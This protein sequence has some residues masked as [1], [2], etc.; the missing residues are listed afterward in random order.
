[1]LPK[2][3]IV[4]KETMKPVY[5]SNFS[6]DSVRLA[7]PH[8]STKKL[9]ASVR[10]M[11]ENYGENLRRE[12]DVS[13]RDVHECEFFEIRGPSVRFK[14][15]QNGAKMH[16]FG[17]KDVRCTGLVVPPCHTGVQSVINWIRSTAHMKAM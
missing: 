13:P 9:N 5:H 15:F 8:E 7:C 16:R 14:D 12:A 11:R 1:M 10:G 6:R 3:G 2:S 4:L 17:G